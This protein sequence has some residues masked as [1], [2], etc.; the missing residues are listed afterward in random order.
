MKRYHL[1]GSYEIYDCLEGSLV[2]S[3]ARFDG[4]N[5]TTPFKT[6]I[7]PFVDGMTPLAEQIG[8]VN[9][10]YREQGLWIGD[11]TDAIALLEMIPETIKR[12]IVLGHGGAAKAVKAVGESRGQEVVC[13][14]REQWYDRHRLMDTADMLINATPIGLQGKGCPVDVLP[15]KNLLIMDMVYEPEKTPLLCLAY[16][17]GYKTLGGLE[18][19]YR[20]ARHSFHRWWGVLP[21][22][23]FARS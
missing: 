15:N 13:I 19:L 17:R 22:L 5:V 12:I 3:F 11:N 18:M 20:Q 23:E 7:K 8:A 6:K 9:T 1:K 16:N 2:E 14:P 21:D 10:L 4:C